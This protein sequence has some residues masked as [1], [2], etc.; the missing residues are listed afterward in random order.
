MDLLCGYILL[1]QLMSICSDARIVC[2][3][4]FETRQK[5]ADCAF[6]SNRVVWG[7]LLVGDAYVNGLAGALRLLLLPLVFP[8]S[9]IKFSFDRKIRCFSERFFYSDEKKMCSDNRNVILKSSISHI[10]RRENQNG[11]FIKVDHKSELP[12]SLVSTN[13][14]ELTCMLNV[15]Q[16]RIISQPCI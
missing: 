15:Y 16:C 2:I 14:L 4:I 11:V 8:L 1:A 9:N 3:P 6:E 5:L 13:G 10:C 7:R 12:T